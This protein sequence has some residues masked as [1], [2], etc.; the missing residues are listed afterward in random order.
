MYWSYWQ[1]ILCIF[2]LSVVKKK[3][4][5]FWYNLLLAYYLLVDLYSYLFTVDTYLLD[6]ILLIVVYKKNKLFQ[7]VLIN[8]FWFE[9]FKLFPD[10]IYQFSESNQLYYLDILLW[11]SFAEIEAR[12]LTIKNIVLIVSILYLYI[13]KGILQ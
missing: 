3:V 6:L 11:Y 8:I 4:I 5:F 10:Y 13:S 12:D 1:F 9:L 7:I 2:I